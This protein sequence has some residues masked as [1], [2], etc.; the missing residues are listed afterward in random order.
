M[1]SWKLGALGACGL[2]ALS[3]SAMADGSAFFPDR[4][5]AAPPKVVDPEVVLFA[6]DDDSVGLGDE[7]FIYSLRGSWLVNGAGADLTVY[8][9]DFGAVEFSLVDVLVSADGLVWVSITG[10]MTTGVR[11]AG[12]TSHGSASHRK[13]F[14]LEGS[15]LS[16]ARFIKLQGLGTGPASGTNGFDLDAIAI[17]NGR[18]PA[19]GT[20]ALVGGVLVMRRRRRA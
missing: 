13:S 3:G 7:R 10:T 2:S 11:V 16:E 18:V 8:E 9:A 1:K 20:L 5:S 12:D 14:D 6:P 4:L 15:G 17:V 19:P